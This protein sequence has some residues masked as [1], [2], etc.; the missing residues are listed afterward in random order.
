MTRSYCYLVASITSLTLSPGL[1]AADCDP[2]SYDPDGNGCI[3][4]EPGYYVPSSGATSQTAAGPGFFVDISGASSQTIVPAGSYTD[5]PASTAPISAPAGSFVPEE[6]ATFYTLA[7]A[8]R[9]Q[10]VEGQTSAKTTPPGSY[11]DQEGLTAPIPAPAGSFVGD[12]GASAPTLAPEGSFVATA[13]QSAAT[14]APA[15]TYTDVSGLT[16]PIPAPAGSFVPV[17]GATFYTLAPVG[18][19]Q[20]MEGQTSAKTTP[21]GSYSDQEGLTAPIPAPAGSFVADAGASAPTPAPPGKFVATEGQSAA[22]LAPAGSFVATEGATVPTSAPAGSYVPLEGQTEATANPP[23]TWTGGGAPAVRTADS[24]VSRGG[25]VV[26]PIFASTP[27]SGS[28]LALEDVNGS[29]GVVLNL[30]NQANDLGAPSEL[31][32]LTI[33]EATVSGPATAAFSLN[34]TLPLTLSE[35]ASGSISWGIDMAS[36]RGAQTLSIQIVTDQHAEPDSAGDSFTYSVHFVASIGWTNW[37][38]DHFSPAEI[39]VGTLTGPSFDADG[40]G[41]PNLVE[42]IFE[43]NP[44]TSLTA[45]ERGFLPRM[46]DGTGGPDIA[47]SLPVG[48]VENTL[49]HID[50]S[51]TLEANSWASIATG[52][53]NGNWTGDASIVSEASGGRINYTITPPAEGGADKSF[54]RLRA[55]QP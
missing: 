55:V 38:E 24:N 9:Y 5:Q 34:E 13:G 50:R 46:V 4:A 12:T 36:L 22:T 37:L 26:G 11:S 20:D 3:L 52:D 48:G 44:R 47:F 2:G 23:G 41:I 19:Y 28:E 49:L 30:Q 21:P 32:D 17:E 8:G 27:I 40:D 29:P 39:T 16:A 10:D 6:G 31:T 15:G 45:T 42:A 53:S 14:L 35:G 43:M 1:W 54:F 7:P 18:R 33:I 25:D 51:L